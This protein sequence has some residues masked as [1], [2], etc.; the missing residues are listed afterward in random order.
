M[1]KK[2]AT[3]PFVYQEIGYARKAKKLII[4]LVEPGIS[5]SQL[6]ML[7][8]LEYIPFDFEDP[9]QGRAQLNQELKKLLD[10]QIAKSRQREALVAGLLVVALL[11]IAADSN[12]TL[13][14]PSA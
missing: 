6:A 13:A 1:S 14:A 2:G 7:E 11:V 8:G 3:S 9:R 12:G 5:S 4:P 10:Q